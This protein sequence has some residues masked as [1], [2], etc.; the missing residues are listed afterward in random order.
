MVPSDHNYLLYSR[1]MGTGL[2]SCHCKIVVSVKEDSEACTANTTKATVY[3]PE[4]GDD[5]VLT[6]LLFAFIP[7]LRK[8]P[9]VWVENLNNPRQFD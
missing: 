6:K 5:L 9:L 8:Q 3:C 7:L 1:L 4:G 2:D